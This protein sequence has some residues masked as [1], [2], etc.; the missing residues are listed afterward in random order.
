MPY[1][2][3]TCKRP[4]LKAS[5]IEIKWENRAWIAFLV[6]FILQG[7]HG[8]EHSS[9]E[10]PTN[11]LLLWFLLEQEFPTPFSRVHDAFSHPPKLRL[12][13]A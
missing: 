3:K 8:M 9:R 5:I 7:L 2:I 11:Q 12:R 1:V 6:V 13:E 4:L 10:A